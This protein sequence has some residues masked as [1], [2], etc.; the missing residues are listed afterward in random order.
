VKYLH[1]DFQSEHGSAEALPAKKLNELAL[2]RHLCATFKL[3]KPI[4]GKITE[5]DVC[6]HIKF[7]TLAVQ[8]I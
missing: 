3:I 4:R 7:K 1:G 6:R 2:P 5:A 8:E